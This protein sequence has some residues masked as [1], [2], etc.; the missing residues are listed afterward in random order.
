VSFWAE[1]AERTSGFVSTA[2][3]SLDAI[4]SSDK[5]ARDVLLE[6]IDVGRESMRTMTEL[7]RHAATR[8]IDELEVIAGKRQTR[9][10]RGPKSP[11]A[12]GRARRAAERDARRSAGG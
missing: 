2:A 5:D 9:H 3:R 6:V 1:W 11:P 8:F 10:A 4:R 12:N 7:P